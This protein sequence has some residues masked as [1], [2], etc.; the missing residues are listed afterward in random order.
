[1][2]GTGGKEIR[3]I[4]VPAILQLMVWRTYKTERQQ[5]RMEVPIE[6]PTGRQVT[7]W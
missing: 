7:V 5:T 4:S 6:R 2:Q 1:M 3:K